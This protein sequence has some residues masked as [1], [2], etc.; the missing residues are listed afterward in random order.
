MPKKAEASKGKSSLGKIAGAV[1]KTYGK[2]KRE[3]YVKRGMSKKAWQAPKI[4]KD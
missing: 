3:D 2:P 4:P 1:K